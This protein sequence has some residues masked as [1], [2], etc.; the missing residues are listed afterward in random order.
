MAHI[1]RHYDLRFPA[2]QQ[3]RPESMRAETQYLPHP[4]ATVEFKRRS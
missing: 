3:G 2:G 4:G 1:L